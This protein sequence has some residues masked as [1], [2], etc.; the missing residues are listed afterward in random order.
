MSDEEDWEKMLD[1]DTLGQKIQDKDDDKFAKEDQV[2]SEEEREKQKIKDKKERE[3]KKVEKE[4]NK[5]NGSS[6]GTAS[7][8]AMLL[9]AIQRL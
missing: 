7:R 9:S 2:D 1:D 5:K 4:Q 6:R 8:K 3:D